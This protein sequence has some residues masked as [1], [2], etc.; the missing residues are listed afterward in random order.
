MAADPA[1]PAT[2]RGAD[3]QFRYEHARQRLGANQQLPAEELLARYP[4]LKSS[5]AAPVI[6]L[7]QCE[8]YGDFAAFPDDVNAQRK[9]ERKARKAAGVTL[10]DNDYH[11]TKERRFNF[12]LSE[13][14]AQ[15]LA[16]HG[17]VVSQRMAAES[18]A[19]VYYRLY[20]DD[21][22]VYVTADSIL[23]AWHRSFDA[24]LVDIE[25]HECIPVLEK[26]L[27]TTS[28]KCHELYNFPA[29]VT[30][31]DSQ[32]KQVL[33]DVDLFLAVA[34]SLLRG[35]ESFSLPANDARVSALY[36]SI[37]AQTT[38]S[39]NLFNSEREVDFSLFKPRGHYTKTKE[40]M[41]YFQAMA[42][43]G[44]ID[45]RIAGSSENPD[46]DLYQLQC[47]IVLVALMRD[48]GRM[49]RLSA[50][51][52]LISSLVGD[53]GVGAD[54]L[55]PMQ[56]DKLLPVS[57]DNVLSLLEAYV[58]HGNT[59][60]QALLTLQLEIVAK[61]LGAQLISGHPHVENASPVV[62][63]VLPTSFAF[64]GQKFVWSSFIFSRLV[65][66]QIVHEE[67]KVA[68]RVPSAIDVAFSL[69]GNDAA[70]AIAAQRMTS[71]SDGKTE[72]LVPLRDGIPYASNLVALRETI[73]NE[74]ASNETVNTEEDSISTLWLRALRELSKP[75][76]N[77]ASVFHS[78]V[79]QLRQLNTQL[80]SFTQLRHDTVLYAKQSYTMQTR[81]E[82]AAGFVDPYPQFYACMQKLATRMVG[83][84]RNLGTPDEDS[85]LRDRGEYLF[86]EFA[87]T[88][89]KLEAI[90]L[91]QL[92]K[93]PLSD[94]QTDFIKTVMEERHGSGATKYAGW[95]PALFYESREDSGKRDVLVVDVHTDTPSIEHND[96]GGVLHLGMGDVHFGFFVIDNVVYSGPVFSSY[97][98]LT[99]IDERLND[100]EFLARV[101]AKTKGISPPEW[102]L[103]SFLCGV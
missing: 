40:L 11:D 84:I 5:P 19:E 68:R 65:Y 63:T 28:T 38:T 29:R 77:Q 43:L 86:E 24:V 4:P 16:Q 76:G 85:T 7:D 8:F 92:D 94:E 59:P 48:T 15:R 83:I 34:V 64:F 17:V 33:L 1:A 69:F 35:E 98:F 18:F 89:T 73:D 12:R 46:G 26:I 70:G 79:W 97:E 60:P 93:Q 21:M 91:C 81:C 90:A 47:A 53:A 14:E 36:K 62:P 25:T 78:N 67:S 37:E 30:I 52:E 103:A 44:T 32:A 58:G 101:D 3:L 39:T 75:S 9:A 56:L 87:E 20:S 45:F 10:T 82:Y 80:A 31:T 71:C 6:A 27:H 74:F 61:G 22:P 99:P 55:T 102:A 49:P 54:S 66:D 13:H 42:W 96:P 23:H 57:G 100:D 51:D 95:Y 41:K 88:M 50:L 72:T 2:T